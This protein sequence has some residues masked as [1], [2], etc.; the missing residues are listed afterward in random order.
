MKN[1]CLFLLTNQFIIACECFL[2]RQHRIAL[3]M[4][5]YL[6]LKVHFYKIV[7]VMDSESS[8]EINILGRKGQGAG[9]NRETS[10]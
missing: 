9:W 1:I 2:G 10:I 5:L 8:L 3:K 6:W 7:T 4:P